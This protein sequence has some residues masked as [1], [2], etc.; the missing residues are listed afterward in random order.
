[1][2]RLQRW[3]F[4]VLGVLV[5]AFLAIQLVPYGR[6][7]TNPPVV[8]EPVWDGPETEELARRAC[9]DCHSNETEWPW[10]SNVA[11]V[12]WLLQRDVEE[13]REHLN[14]SDW[15]SGH[16]REEDHDV[17]EMVKTILEGEMPPPSYLPLH[18][19]ARL[20]AA[21][22]ERLAQG[23]GTLLAIQGQPGLELEED[24][25]EEKEEDH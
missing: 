17:D 10:Y 18:P 15:D 7:H 16:H 24:E 3:I 25:H 5:V 12:S 9:Y 23:L 20:T 8:S 6:D 4:I 14:F 19:E 2:K 21:E 22:K 13:G 1:M 11:P